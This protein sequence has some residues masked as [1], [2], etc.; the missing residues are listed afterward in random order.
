MDRGETR[1]SVSVTTVEF[2]ASGTGTA[3]ILTEHGAFFD[4]GDKPE[5]REEG[6]RSLIDGLEA[7]LGRP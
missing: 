5:H 7:A 6:T 4:G 2:L 3:L 1:I